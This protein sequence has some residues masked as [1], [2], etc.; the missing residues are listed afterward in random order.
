[1]LR[2]LHRN[3]RELLGRRGRG[4][5]GGAAASGFAEAAA[6]AS[7]AEESEALRR[8]AGARLAAGEI[9]AAAEA[10][11][12]AIR[13][14]PSRAVLHHDLGLALRAAGDLHGALS[15]FEKAIAL[16]H[17]YVPALYRAGELLAELG[18]EEEARDCLSL[19]LAFDPGSSASRLALCR[20]LAQ[21][22]GLEAAIR[23]LREAV[24]EQ[25]ADAAV[26]CRLAEL[27]ERRGDAQGALAA[28]EAAVERFPQEPAAL[29]HLGLLE[30]GVRGDAVRA[31]ALFRR[32]LALDPGLVAAR[33]NL[34]LALQDQGRF[35]E[36]LAHY[37]QGI[38]E[39][40]DVAEFR[41]N[42]GLARLA[43]G[44]FAAGWEDY[45]LRKERPDAGGVHERFTLPDWDGC[46]LEGRAILVYGEQGLG[47]EIMFASCL[48]D[49]LARAALCVIE[50]DAR[51]APLYRRSFPAARVEP[52]VP[53]R[54][55]DWRAAYPELEL[56]CA[57]GS[58]PRFL[59]RSAA[60]F[61]ARCGYLRADPQAAARWRERLGARGAAPR[62]GICWRGGTA[63]TRAALRSLPLEHA[64]ALLDTPRASFVVLQRGLTEAERAMLAGR[65]VAHVAE[66]GE[67]LD[68]LAALIEALD[69][70]V[71]VPSTPL[72]LAGALGRPVL[73]L[74][75]ASP[76]WR[77][78]REGERMP[79]YP[80]VKLL[81]QPRPGDWGAVVAQA[82][83]LL[84]RLA[85]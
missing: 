66:P 64:A 75:G 36:A 42:R 31:E 73:G 48:P 9:P 23:L 61:P 13:I 60:D 21:R 28:C 81:R 6:P 18:R 67:S 80:S 46:P 3:L 1:M 65:A 33:A 68:A 17:D 74:L 4:S 53:G 25:R 5:A 45:E 34:G 50:C 35:E 84:G 55:R 10:L 26:Y 40:P 27:L 41:W 12:R 8:E 70:V 51:L 39:H 72:H 82:R 14:A 19:A 20:L 58:L 22:E 69:L 79:W 52:R 62:V 32:A 15:A 7:G 44:D 30:L 78:G 16:R 54:G 37:E 43:L 83:E 38:A 47:D 77:Y 56:Q 29:V 85:G 71:S 2:Q 59:R 11:R 63:R 49:V 57:V 24:L 76:E